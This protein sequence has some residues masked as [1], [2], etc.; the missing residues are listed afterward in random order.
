MADHPCI[1]PSRDVPVRGRYDVIVAG[2]GLGGVAAAAAAA[3]AGAKTLLIERNGFLGGVATAGMCCS[4]FNCYY[5]GGEDRRLGTSGIAVEVAD[6]LAA[7]E[8]Y[9]RKWHRHKGHVIYDVESGKLVLLDLLAGAGV[10]V[11][12]NA[13]I[14]GV[15]MDG[16]TLRGVI[17]ESKSGR[18]AVLAKVVVD[19]TG[20]ADVAALAVAPVRVARKPGMHSFCF[21]LGNVDVDAFV[22]YFRRN[23]EQFPEYMDVD[24]SLAEALRQYD[25]CGTFLFPHGGGMQ[26]DVLKRAKAGGDLPAHVGVHQAIDACQMHAIRRLGVVHVITG[27]V[28]FDGLDIGRISRSIHDGRRMAFVM[29]NVYRKHVPGFADA[30]VIGTAENLGVRVSRYLAA[31][32]VFTAEMMQAGVRQAD[33][34]GRAVGWDAVVKHPGPDAWGVQVCRGDSFDL[35]YRCLIPRRVDGLLMGAGRSVSA[36][37]PY[38][39]RAMAHTMVVGQGAGAAAAVSAGT[40]AVPRRVD[41]AAVQAELR[42]QTVRC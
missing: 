17:I 23:P 35:P 34:V 32:F 8:G 26:L 1:E 28:F 40:G 38:L 24:W 31:E 25:D 36:D 13:L 4:I 11:L 22:D 21:R 37:N 3:R 39:L 41:V 29:S 27:Q 15:V 2:G 30:F 14:A 16:Q 19:A 7:A 6:A 5:T 12:V 33:A 18:E 42:K 10:E 9:G 20:D